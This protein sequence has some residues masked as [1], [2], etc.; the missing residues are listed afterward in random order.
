VSE[1]EWEA[2]D[3]EVRLEPRGALVAG[4]GSD[5]TPGL[6][7]VEAVLAGAGTWLARPGAAVIELAPHQAEAAVTMAEAIGATSAHVEPDLAGRPRVLLA[8]FT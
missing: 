6:A 8:R 5:G 2:L 3:A 7:G 4:P 1:S